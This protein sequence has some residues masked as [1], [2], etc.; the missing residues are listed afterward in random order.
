MNLFCTFQKEKELFQ[1]DAFQVVKSLSETG[2]TGDF[3]SSSFIFNR[4]KWQK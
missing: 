3:S 4:Q 1:K 2:M